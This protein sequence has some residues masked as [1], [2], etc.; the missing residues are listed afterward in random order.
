MLQFPMIILWRS[1]LKSMNTYIQDHLKTMIIAESSY[2]IQWLSYGG[3]C[4]KHPS[5]T[6]KKLWL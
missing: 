1:L 4:W 2:N 6:I 5:R 3:A